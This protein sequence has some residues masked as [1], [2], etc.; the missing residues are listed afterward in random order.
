MTT[1]ETTETKPVT[2]V[3][4]TVEREGGD[5]PLAWILLVIIILG[6]A[7]HGACGRRMGRG[8]HRPPPVHLRVAP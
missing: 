1:T 2:I 4:K 3:T 6:L 8:V 7:S 5:S